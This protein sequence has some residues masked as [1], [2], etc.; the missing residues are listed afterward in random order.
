MSKVLIV[1]DNDNIRNFTG[2]FMSIAGHTTKKEG[3]GY[4]G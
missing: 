1:E 3:V 2:R 4:K